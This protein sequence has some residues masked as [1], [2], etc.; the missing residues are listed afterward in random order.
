MKLL[1]NLIT[2]LGVQL[3]T[4]SQEFNWVKTI[5][6]GSGVAGLDIAIDLDGNIFTA[7]EVYPD[8][9]DF[10]P[11]ADVYEIETDDRSCWIQKLD[12]AGNFLWAKVLHGNCV[13]R[14]IETDIEGNVY[15][16][17]FF[18]G[19]TDFDPGPETYNITGSEPWDMFLV[20]LDS[21]GNFE[22]VHNVGDASYN[23][24]SSLSVGGDGV[25]LSGEFDGTIDID[26]SADGVFNISV[27]VGEEDYTDSFIRKVGFD[28]E[29]IW[30][31]KFNTIENSLRMKHDQE[32]NL[33]ISGDFR[34]AIDIAPLG[35]EYIVTAGADGE[36]SFLVKLDETDTFVWGTSFEYSVIN[37][38]TDTSGSVY[39]NG[40]FSGEVDMNPGVGEEFFYSDE[41]V[42][43]LV[44]L[45]PDGSFL[46]ANVNLQPVVDFFRPTSI[47]VDVDGHT[48]LSGLYYNTFDIAAGPEVFEIDHFD[49]EDSYL[50]H[51]DSE[52]NFVE[53]STVNG[54]NSQR[55][56]D[57]A[58]SPLGFMVITGSYNEETDFNM[59]EGEAIEI[60]SEAFNDAF[61]SRLEYECYDYS[62]VTTATVNSCEEYLW[63]INDVS[64]GYTGVY[65]MR[66]KDITGCDSIH[67][68]DYHRPIDSTTVSSV[69]E[70][71]SFI[72][73]ESGEEYT[74]S[75]NYS[76]IYINE[77]GCDSVVSI[78]ITIISNDLTITRDE[79]ELKVNTFVADLYQWGKCTDAGFE[80]IDGAIFQEYDV[81]ENGDYAVEVTKDGCTGL[82][83]C[84]TVEDVGIEL[85][86]FNQVITVYPNPTNQAFQVDLGDINIPIELKV[87]NVLGEEVQTLSNEKGNLINVMLPARKGVYIL[88]ILSG[89]S[90]VKQIEVV[91][92]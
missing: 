92:N 90:L 55:I 16:A 4:F 20:K 9:V 52:G 33:F 14:E 49:G 21:D 68:L 19:T 11:G 34:G 27:T 12:S 62:N 85:I 39:L 8:N 32:G 50:L 74:E 1:L 87:Y 58:C 89:E 38:A 3:I 53:A 83:D 6:S 17:G 61:V 29:F 76:I 64:Y 40:R 48:Y 35:G 80:P 47:A 10:D 82:S 41:D 71:N 63:E 23:T 81:L 42:Q 2:L 56:S 75:G 36:S 54:P 25:Y 66:F 18:I 51:I 15:V 37:L 86:N 43:C 79:L 88:Q 67:I 7:G 73:D 26:P 28:G 46:W 22:W 24:I 59:G 78:G 31:S 77:A 13:S 70:C 57:V 69:T 65:K 5:N 45:E 72:W 91:K 84:I 60:V 30:G 44:K